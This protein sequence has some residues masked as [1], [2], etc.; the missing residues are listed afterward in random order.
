VRTSAGDLAAAEA[1]Y[2]RMLE[3]YQTVYGG[4]HAF[5]GIAM[6]NLANVYGEVGDY[7]S[8]EQMLRQAIEQFTGALGAEHS[9]TAIAVIKLGGVLRRQE[10][11]AEAIQALRSGHDLLSVQADPGARFLQIARSELARAYEAIVDLE[12]AGR[13]QAAHARHAEP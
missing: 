1:S 7:A 4:T 2:R 8:A 5:S 10:R 13:W 9:N 11:W 3:I 6:S 12:E